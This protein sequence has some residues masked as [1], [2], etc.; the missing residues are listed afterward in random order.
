MAVAKAVTKKSLTSSIGSLTS[1]DASEFLTSSMKANYHTAP[2]R[3]ALIM[4]T[5]RNTVEVWHIARIEKR[6]GDLFLEKIDMFK[7]SYVTTSLKIHAV[8]RFKQV[9]PKQNTHNTHFPTPKILNIQNLSSNLT[10]HLASGSQEIIM[11]VVRANFEGQKKGKTFAK[12]SQ[13][14]LR[15][16]VRKTGYEAGTGILRLHSNTTFSRHIKT[17]CNLLVIGTGFGAGFVY[18]V[19]V[20]K[21]VFLVQNSFI[22]TG[23]LA[24]VRYVLILS[25]LGIQFGPVTVSFEAFSEHK[26]IMYTLKVGFTILNNLIQHRGLN[27]HFILQIVSRY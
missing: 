18:F 2:E 9:H 27:C 6:D 14:I 24:C 5:R 8:K 7:V 13:L 21:S 1:V 19:F 16:L 11:V 15:H 12:I 4:L 10:S 17:C 22:K 25:V 23:I 3:P 26:R 20:C